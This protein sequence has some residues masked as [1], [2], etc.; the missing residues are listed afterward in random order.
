MA[1]QFWQ[2]RELYRDP[3]FTPDILT[4]IKAKWL[5]VHG[6]DDEPVPVQQAVEMHQYIPNSRLWIIPNGGNLP[7][8]NA[9]YQP[10]FL[11]VSLEFLNGKWDKKDQG[12]E[13][14]LGFCLLPS[15]KYFLLGICTRLDI[16]KYHHSSKP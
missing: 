12:D 16:I 11:K 9:D 4:T 2:F 15:T 14:L 7:H 8:L 13:I 5:I 3:S 1:R 10:E 6:D